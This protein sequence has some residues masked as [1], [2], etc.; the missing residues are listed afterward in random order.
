MAWI[1]AEDIPFGTWAGFGDD[2]RYLLAHDDV[3][4]GV[5]GWFRREGRW[6][7]TLDFVRPDLPMRPHEPA[8]PEV[9]SS[10]SEHLR[11]IET[12]GCG[13]PG[14]CRSHTS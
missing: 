13:A 2:R 14:W 9:L 5:F 10:L 11:A 1:K 8:D 7:H 4:G 12:D 3:S 6:G